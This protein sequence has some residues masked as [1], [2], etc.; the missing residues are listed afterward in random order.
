MKLFYKE[1]VD[2]E[3][4]LLQCKSKRRGSVFKVL[5]LRSQDCRYNFRTG[6]CI[7]ILNRRLH[8]GLFITAISDRTKKDIT[9][10]ENYTFLA[11][12][13]QVSSALFVR[14][15]VISVVYMPL[16]PRGGPRHKNTVQGFDDDVKNRNQIYLREIKKR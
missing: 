6:W 14:N 15:V 8:S 7:A 2:F 12:L 4:F 13:Y 11:C 1:V 5:H 3:F 10:Q 16:E 9:R